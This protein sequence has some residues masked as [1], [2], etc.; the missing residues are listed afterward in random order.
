MSAPLAPYVR[1]E[2]KSYHMTRDVLLAAIPLC[3]F[4]VV[5]YGPRPLW[6]VLCSMLA[7][8]VSE[9]ICCLLR[10]KSVRT[11]FDSSAAVT[12]VII[13]LLMSPMVSYWV[14]MVGSA[15]AVFVAKAPFGGYGRNMFNP[16]AAGIAFLSY[17]TPRRMFTY[18]AINPAAALPTGMDI[19]FGTVV[20]GTSLLGHLRAGDAP[21]VDRMQLLIG[22]FSGPIGATAVLI[23]LACAAFLIFRRAA[24]PVLTLSY[25]GTCVLIAWMFPAQGFDKFTGIIAQLG[26]GYTLFTGVFL[27]ND[28]VTAPR[29]WIAR[30]FYGSFTAMLV[31][32]L[33]HIGR[34]FP[35]NGILYAIP[36]GCFAILLM[37]AIAPII[38]RWTWH[39]VHRLRRLFRV[40][41]E[42]SAHE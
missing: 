7:A 13:G 42:V 32:L 11:L 34:T 25:I 5:N 19:P 8:I 4:S 33:Q 12:G 18:P 31:M 35:E 9:M 2:N 29:Y 40:R 14:P 24:S 3:A 1:D 15:F 27:L 36:G 21:T 38:D 20:S 16:A 41:G 17:V 39:I 26:A 30:V 6:I 28:P 10:H 37:N 22:E 23:L